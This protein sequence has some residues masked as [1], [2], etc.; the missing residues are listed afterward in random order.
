MG[1]DSRMFYDTQGISNGATY[2]LHNFIHY[3]CRLKEAIRVSGTQLRVFYILLHMQSKIF[4][5]GIQFISEAFQNILFSHQNFEGCQ[6]L[7]FLLTFYYLTK[8]NMHI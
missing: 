8:I 6:L 7:V 3:W 2:Y 5:N 1:K 4:T